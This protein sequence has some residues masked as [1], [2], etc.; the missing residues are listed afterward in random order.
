MFIR[1]VYLV[2]KIFKIFVPLIIQNINN[3]FND[4]ET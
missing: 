3:I 4:K 1:N 2:N